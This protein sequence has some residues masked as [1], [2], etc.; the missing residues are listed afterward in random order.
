M[1]KDGFMTT[2]FLALDYLRILGMFAVVAIHVGALIVETPD[3]PVTLFA[4]YE[5]FSRYGIPIFFFI[6]GFGLFCRIDLTQSF[7]YGNF[8]R[9]SFLK[10]FGTYVAWCAFYV[11]YYTEHL[12][13]FYAVKKIFSEEFFYA[14]TCGYAGYHLYFMLLLSVFYL[15]MPLWVVLLRLMNRRPVLWFILLGL[16]QIVFNQ[17][18]L[19]NINPIGSAWADR[20]LTHQLNWICL[21]YLAT[22]MLGAYLGNNR[23]KLL[24]LLAKYRA[25]IYAAC[26]LSIGYL[27]YELHYLLYVREYT[28]MQIAFTLHQLSIPGWLYCTSFILAAFAFLAEADWEHWSGAAAGKFLSSSSNI[29]YFV[30]PVFLDQLSIFAAEQAIVLTAKKSLLVYAVAMLLSL[31]TAYLYKQLRQR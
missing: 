7:A 20:Y 17:W 16:F 29:V 24:P 5:V 18:A 26:L 13:P 22:F 1:D 30:H 4:L 28:P 10:L 9:H 19:K 2:R 25:A 31:L 15:T 11:L 3:F 8:L 14:V 21:Y 27:T 6:S 12:R 23:T